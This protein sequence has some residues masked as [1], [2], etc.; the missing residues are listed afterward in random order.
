MQSIVNKTAVRPV[1]G[2]RPARSATFVVRA[3]GSPINPSIRKSE[4]KVVDFLKVEDIKGKA[5]MCRCWKSA[6][7]PNCNGSHVAH[8]KA[9]G[10]NV[11]PLIVEQAK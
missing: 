5:V 1:A 3:E 11:G 7:F 4:E 8:N 6:T 10:D 9:T 2:S